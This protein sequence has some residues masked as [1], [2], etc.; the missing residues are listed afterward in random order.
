MAVSRQDVLEVKAALAKA[1]TEA[2]RVR[3]PGARA[4]RPSVAPTTARRDA[5]IDLGG[6]AS[7]SVAQLTAAVQPAVE[8]AVEPLR[9]RGE[10]HKLVKALVESEV[11]RRLRGGAVDGLPGAG[12]VRR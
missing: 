9:V 7:L 5:R 10:L 12:P 3:R 1:M 2:A 8:R 6:G 4:W 11:A